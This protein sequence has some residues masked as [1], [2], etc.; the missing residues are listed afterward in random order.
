MQYVLKMKISITLSALVAVTTAQSPASS[1]SAP[2]PT[3]FISS[4][5]AHAYNATAPST[6]SIDIGSQID[7]VLTAANPDLSDY[8]SKKSA[9]DGGSADAGQIA[10][11][12]IDSQ[13]PGASAILSKK[14]STSESPEK[15]GHDTDNA[16]LGL[17]AKNAGAHIRVAATTSPVTL[18]T[19]APTARDFGDEIQAAKSNLPKSPSVLASTPR[20]EVPPVLVPIVSLLPDNQRKFVKDLVE[21]AQYGSSPAVNIVD[22]L[23]TA[24]QKGTLTVSLLLD[25]INKSTLGQVLGGK[26]GVLGSVVDGVQGSVGDLS[27][28][29]GGVVHGLLGH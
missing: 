6:T 5:R 8:I 10:D 24:V 11:E 9:L 14:P 7:S 23:I 17:L 13:F 16:I 22:G 3:T 27:T 12:I 20:G 25:G 26:K 19:R 18:P 21:A 15:I 29:L 1:Q 28:L 4:L 2:T